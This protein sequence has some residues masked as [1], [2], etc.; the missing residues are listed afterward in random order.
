FL[1]ATKEISKSGHTLVHEVIPYINVLTE[2]VNNIHKNS[3]LTIPVRTAAK[4][5][6]VRLDKYYT[7]TDDCIVHRV[8]MI[9]HP[10]YKK[11]YF[12]CLDWPSEWISEAEELVR[13]EWR[14]YYKPKVSRIQPAA[15]PAALLASRNMF[16][17]IMAGNTNNDEDVLEAYLDGPALTTV[18]DPIAHWE[19]VYASAARKDPACKGEKQLALMA[20]DFLS[21]QVMQVSITW[22]AIVSLTLISATSTDAE[23]T[24][25]HGGL[26]VLKFRHGL[27]DE[28]MRAST[29]LGSWARLN[30][31]LLEADAIDVLKAASRKQDIGLTPPPTAVPSGSSASAFAA[32][33]T[34]T[35]ASTA[36]TSSAAASVGSTC[37]N[38]GVPKP[39]PKGKGKS[40]VAVS[41]ITLD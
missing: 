30:N 26:M 34:S 19:L 3:A 1:Y 29:L 11:E 25:S 40:A 9:L 21:S 35:T 27:A 16:A 23:R 12:R 6:H 22:Y 24:F 17:F 7:L 18:K 20:L 41:M 4:C 38:K 28:S 39:R 32:H 10:R 31:L 37:T 36:R 2:H 14:S 15:C 5:G 13:N 8:A 33:A